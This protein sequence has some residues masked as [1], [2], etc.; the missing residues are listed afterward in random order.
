MIDAGT[1]TE[2]VTSKE[3]YKILE[4]RL[5][6]LSKFVLWLPG[7]HNKTCYIVSNTSNK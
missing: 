2:Q 3:L 1:R 4:V 7:M 6:E 5:A